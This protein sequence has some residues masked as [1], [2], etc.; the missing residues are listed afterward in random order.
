M[1]AMLKTRIYD[2]RTVLALRPQPMHF[3]IPLLRPQ[4]IPTVPALPF[5]IVDPCLPTPPP[6][7]IPLP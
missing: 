3:Y 4:A 7:S 2:H 6:H 1:P 5:A